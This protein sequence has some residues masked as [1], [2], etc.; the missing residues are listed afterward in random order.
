MN[1]NNKNNNM[2]LF[3][4]KPRCNEKTIN[5]RAVNN[6][7]DIIKIF[8]KEAKNRNAPVFMFE[9]F[10]NRFQALVKIL[11]S[12][13]TRDE[14]TIEATK[15]LFSTLKTPRQLLNLST[16]KIENLI[17]PV[18]FYKTKAKNLKKIAKILINQYHSRTPLQFEEL[19]KLPGVGRKT[20]NVLLATY[21][22]KQ[23]IAV[24]VHVHR[25]SNRIGLV[26]TK[27]PKQTEKELKKIIPKKYWNK[28]NKAFVA[29]GQTICKPKKPRCEE[30]KIKDI[31]SKINV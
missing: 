13:R 17:K 29:Y 22:K 31:C 10:G 19:I 14:I 16:I 6:I 5:K 24:D 18:A 26:K 23:V 1:T 11:L 12:S 8:L 9:R 15:R 21:D 28:I 20:A 7:K 25:I 30:C 2:N 4:I 3:N 27:T